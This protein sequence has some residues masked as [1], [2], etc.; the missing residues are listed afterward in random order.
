MQVYACARGYPQ[1]IQGFSP[2]RFI[3]II[4]R[5][6]V[7]FF[8]SYNDSRKRIWLLKEEDGMTERRS[9]KQGLLDREIGSCPDEDQEF[10]S[11]VVDMEES[12]IPRG[13]RD[14]SDIEGTTFF[15]E[16]LEVPD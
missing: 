16:A 4:H 3:F 12:H 13:H 6:C 9:H 2:G 11:Q 10:V 7:F 14:L 5:H 8:R 1:D 15:E